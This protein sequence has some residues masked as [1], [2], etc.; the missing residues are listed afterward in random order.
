MSLTL[1]PNLSQYENSLSQTE[2]RK[3]DLIQQVLNVHS[4]GSNEKENILDLFKT[5]KNVLNL[6]KKSIARMSLDRSEMSF[7]DKC[8]LK[9]NI[10]NLENN[11]PQSFVII[12]LYSNNHMFATVIRKRDEQFIS[13]IV[14]KGDRPSAHGQ[15]VEHKISEAGMEEILSELN[16]SLGKKSTKAIYTIFNKHSDSHRILNISSSDQKVGNCFIKEPENAIKFAF[17]TIDFTTEKFDD[18]FHNKINFKPK[19]DGLTVNMHRAFVEQVAKEHVRLTPALQSE[20]YIYEI[21]KQFREAVEQD[22]DISSEQ[23]TSFLPYINMDTLSRFKC[24]MAINNAVEQTEG[25]AKIEDLRTLSQMAD[26]SVRDY[27]HK[28]FFDDLGRLEKEYPVLARQIKY[29]KHSDLLMDGINS[30]YTILNSK[31]HKPANPSTTLRYLNDSVKLNPNNFMSHAVLGL[32]HLEFGHYDKARQSLNKAIEL[33]EDLASL[34][35]L[36]SQVYVKLNQPLLSDSDLK[37]VKR[38]DVDGGKRWKMETNFDVL[39]EYYGLGFS[40]KVLPEKALNMD[41]SKLQEMLKRGNVVRGG[42]QKI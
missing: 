27:G 24:A 12:P 22:K 33:R 30:L 32:T 42:L 39:T 5:Y 21:N 8:T 6:T 19:W 26:N 40:P 34:Y 4:N 17:A 37:Q 1:T 36:R 20:M 11:N 13:T 15:F 31:K 10:K 16:T 14:N 18:L 35:Y 9:I 29:E 38:L 2:R 7:R 3:L 28:R 25:A 41:T 23:A